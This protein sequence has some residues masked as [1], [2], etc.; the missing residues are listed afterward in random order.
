MNFTAL[1]NG[2]S[3]AFYHEWNCSTMSL[4]IVQRNYKLKSERAAHAIIRWSRETLS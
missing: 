4:S 3:L 2:Y 1:L